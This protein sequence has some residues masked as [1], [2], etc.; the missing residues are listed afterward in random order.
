MLFNKQVALFL[1]EMSLLK[2]TA[3]TLQVILYEVPIFC[4][5]IQSFSISKL[6]VTFNF[7]LH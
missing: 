1:K 7:R 4:S 3:L 5:N 6:N 2:Y